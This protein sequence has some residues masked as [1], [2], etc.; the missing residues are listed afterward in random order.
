MPAMTTVTVFKMVS[1]VSWSCCAVWMR[2]S[3]SS[4]LPRLCAERSRRVIVALMLSS[5]PRSRTVNRIHMSG[6]RWLPCRLASVLNGMITWLSWLWPK[7]SPFGSSR[8]MI[9]SHSPLI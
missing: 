4:S 3:S 8:P 6:S 2:K 1:N 5:S 9:L 7:I